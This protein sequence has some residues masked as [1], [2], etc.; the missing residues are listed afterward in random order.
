[1]CNRTIEDNVAAFSKLSLTTVRESSENAVMQAG[2]A[3][4]G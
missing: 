2:K 1:M 4:Q 3:K